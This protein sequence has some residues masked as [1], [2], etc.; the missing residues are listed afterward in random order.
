[1]KRDK[2]IKILNDEY[3]PIMAMQD[4]FNGLQLEGKAEINKVLVV[5]DLTMDIVYQAISNKV[6]MIITHHPLFFGEVK[7]IIE[8]N[9]ILKSKIKI[10]TDNNISVYVIHT[11]ADFAP[12]S[13]AFNQALALNFEKVMQLE[14]NIGVFAQYNKEKTL[15]EIVDKI[16][17]I[18]LLPYSFR[19]NSNLTTYY[20]EVII[21]SGASGELVFHKNALGKLLII[22]E[23]KHHHW[24]EANKLGID[25]LEIG[26]YSEH[27]F[28]SMIEALLIDEEVKVII[29]E[30]ENGY[31]HV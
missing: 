18:L 13:I 22:G 28:K 30:E 27:I 8:S 4:D 26:H 20:K 14:N 16:R 24:V 21:G 25:V 6:D 19:T 9:P 10:L 2:L 11:P 1:M 5:L 29:G 15:E 12:S 3:P 17:N 23:M 31:K 7:K